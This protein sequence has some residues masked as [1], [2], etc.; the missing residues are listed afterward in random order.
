MERDETRRRGTL[1]LDVEP[2]SGGDPL[3]QGVRGRLSPR[4]RYCTR[5]DSEPA[6]AAT[7]IT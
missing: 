6:G 2:L 4:A 5:G 1:P 7:L 3:P